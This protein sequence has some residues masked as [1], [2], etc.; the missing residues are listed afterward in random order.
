MNMNDITVRMTDYISDVKSVDLIGHTIKDVT[1]IIKLRLAFADDFRLKQLAKPTLII[2]VDA[3]AGMIN[4]L[5]PIQLALLELVKIVFDTHNIYLITFGGYKSTCSVVNNEYEVKYTT[6]AELHVHNFTGK[7]I[8]TIESAINAIDLETQTSFKIAFD[9]IRKIV[10]ESIPSPD[11]SELSVIFLAGSE[12]TT[13]D[14]I[15]KNGTEVSLNYMSNI[16]A[17]YSC[18]PTI[19]LIG[20]SEDHD[21]ALIGSVAS[22]FPGSTY[23]YVTNNNLIIEKI[24][25][26]V[27]LLYKQSITC[28]VKFCGTT[29][30]VNILF[31]YNDES[32]RGNIRWQEGIVFVPLSCDLSSEVTV[33]FKTP[34]KTNESQSSCKKLAVPR[35]HVTNLIEEYLNHL[36]IEAM[37][38]FSKKSLVEKDYDE[39]EKR[40]KFTDQGYDFDETLLEKFC[41]VFMKRYENKLD[42]DSI[43]DLYDTVYKR[44]FTKHN[45]KSKQT[46]TLAELSE[47]YQD[48]AEEIGL[49]EEHYDILEKIVDRLIIYGNMDPVRLMKM[50]DCACICVNMNMKSPNN[51]KILKIIPALMGAKVFQEECRK[52]VEKAG[53]KITSIDSPTG[54][55]MNAVIPLCLFDEH[56]DFAKIW[57]Y[58]LYE[59][60]GLTKEQA[61]AI[62]FILLSKA[63]FDIQE[64]DNEHTKIIAKLVIDTCMHIYKDNQ[65][66]LSRQVKESFN[67]FISDP[68]GRTV[69]K[70]PNSALF[71]AQ[72][73]IA[74][75]FQDIEKLSRE[76]AIQFARC[77]TEEEVRRSLRNAKDINIPTNMMFEI[78]QA[79]RTVWVD[80][81]VKQY[82]DSKNA[83]MKELVKVARHLRSQMLSKIEEKS[84]R[85][86]LDDIS[87]ETEDDTTEELSE[88]DLPCSDPTKW[89]PKFEM[90]KGLGKKIVE[91]MVTD[92]AKH[93][94]SNLVL[95]P[96][97]T[98]QKDESINGDF[99]VLG[100]STYEQQIAFT[101]QNFMHAKGNRRVDAMKNGT[102]YD[103]FD[104][105][106][107]NKYLKRLFVEYVN[108]EKSRL[109]K[110]IDDKYSIKTDNV[111]AK[112][113]AM[114]DDPITSAGCLY[115]TRIGVD[116]MNFAILLMN[117]K[118]PLAK[119]KITML[120]TGEFRGIKLYADSSKEQP[121]WKPSRKNAHRLWEMNEE[122]MDFGEWLSLLES[123]KCDHNL[124]EWQRMKYVREGVI[125][126][127]NKYRG[128]GR[129]SYSAYE[130]VGLY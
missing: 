3:S 52:A 54:E 34:K 58:K 22:L 86:N 19:H 130:A 36:V 80:N 29:Y 2:V 6:D 103:V 30:P 57:L 21:A 26:I 63:M 92:Y 76:D 113:F 115:Q 7:D 83:S 60:Y 46:D 118:C 120:L 105:D 111:K 127:D 50:G 61:N 98:N 66:E 9:A 72:L 5:K 41:D 116:V 94:L 43:A 110:I 11:Q 122:I 40:F 101:I 106:Q 27:P 121:G 12:D 97:L 91:R 23:Q 53:A 70:I 31:N 99:S 64:T 126:D 10:E 88:N 73:I 75:E 71:L 33:T 129:R 123:V 17:G 25:N 47:T 67:L 95:L 89:E 112:I 78:L 32:K 62:P 37:G 13:T 108:D 93:G 84:D 96:F 90:L 56:Y 18:R 20:I 109:M 15:H 74:Q 24:L 128:K 55:P 77:I 4:R 16:L 124:K 68:I 104:N 102:Y 1:N 85:V 14:H 45:V 44:E 38:V 59:P 8:K 65:N 100:I 114:T 48:A 82:H 81:H 42:K 69:E 28:D 39:M 117:H 107:A 119:E 51:I 79:D 49:Y 87:T 35:E 125:P